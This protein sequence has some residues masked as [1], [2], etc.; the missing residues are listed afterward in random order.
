MKVYYR[1]PVDRISRAMTEFKR[2][3][4]KYPNVIDM[5]TEEFEE[6]YF[7]CNKKKPTIEN[8]SFPTEE[9][10][11]FRGMTITIVDEPKPCR[12]DYR[13]GKYNV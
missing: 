3:H 12:V 10:Q 11:E 5:S 4:D 1:E 13:E 6:L 8:P 9:M 2:K 7:E